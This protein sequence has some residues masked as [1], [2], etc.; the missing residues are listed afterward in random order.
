MQKESGLNILGSRLMDVSL[1]IFHD[2]I[3]LLT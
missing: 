2:V 3:L 1:I